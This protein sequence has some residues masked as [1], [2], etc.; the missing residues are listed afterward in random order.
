MIT[1]SSE[2]LTFQ[3]RVE[4]VNIDHE[5]RTNQ[6]RFIFNCGSLFIECTKFKREQKKTDVPYSPLP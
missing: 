6:T 2:T 1:F 5:I 3:A 4:Y